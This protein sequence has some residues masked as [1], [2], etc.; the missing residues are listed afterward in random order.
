LSAGA[1]KLRRHASLTVCRH[2]RTRDRAQLSLPHPEG[3]GDAARQPSA[4]VNRP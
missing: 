2:W 1:L 4:H 3:A